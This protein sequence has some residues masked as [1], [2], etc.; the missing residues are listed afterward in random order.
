[1]D[2]LLNQ[3]FDSQKIKENAQTESMRV[4]PEPGVC[5]KLKCDSG[6]KIFANICISNKIPMPDEI[7]EGALIKMLEN[8]GEAPPYR[9]PLSIGDAHC[10]VDNSGKPCSAYDV[11]I[12]PGF[13]EKVKASDV[14]MGFLVTVIIE[15][16]ETKFKL[17]IRK[18]ISRTTSNVSEVKNAAPKSSIPEFKMSAVPDIE[19]PK[20]IVTKLKLP[21]LSSSRGIE[22]DIGSKLFVLRTRSRIYEMAAELS[23][24][25]DQANARAE[26]N[27]R[28][29][30]L[31]V[32][33][34]VV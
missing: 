15:S 5:V 9:V 11:I 21:E 33:M 22:L 30:I 1:M 32:T 3:L 6:S 25:I 10:E 24:T 26:F 8:T 14:F 16:L 20:F 17:S 4:V 28:T 27:N 31:T 7:S 12:N 13:L 19:N 18:G 23:H 2:E 34:P 29:K